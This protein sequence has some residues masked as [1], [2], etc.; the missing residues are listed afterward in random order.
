MYPGLVVA[1]LELD[2]S[3]INEFGQS[4]LA[5]SVLSNQPIGN[6]ANNDAQKS[7]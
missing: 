5:A 3:V 7:D 1:L 2:R 4:V 6:S